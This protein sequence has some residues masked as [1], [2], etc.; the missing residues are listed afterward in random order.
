CKRSWRRGEPWCRSIVQCR[1]GRHA[2]CA[3]ALHPATGRFSNGQTQQWRDEG[4]WREQLSWRQLAQ[5]ERTFGLER[6]L[7]LRI[8][9]R[10]Q[11]VVEQW[12]FLERA[13]RVERT[14]LGKLTER[15]QLSR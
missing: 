13:R 7:E 11:S 15:R 14:Q 4:E 5:R 12:R 9:R 6:R 10:H 1:R 2:S 8:A 3:P